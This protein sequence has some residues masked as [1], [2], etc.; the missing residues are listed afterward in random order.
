LAKGDNLILVLTNWVYKK[1][2]KI[3]KN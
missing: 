2:L 1:Y 3:E